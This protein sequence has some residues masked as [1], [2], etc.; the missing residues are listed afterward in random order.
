MACLGALLY[1]TWSHRNDPELITHSTSTPSESKS[2]AERYDW[3]GSAQDP[4]KLLIG[5]INVDVY[6]QRMGVDQNQEIAVPNNVFLAGWFVS[7]AQPGQKGLAII[8]GHVSGLENPGVF[9]HLD[10]MRVGDSFR[11]VR[12]DNTTLDYEVIST[13]TV[14]EQ[15]AADAIF[16]QDPST[17]SQVNLVTC[18]GRFDGKTN[19][20]DKRVIVAGKLIK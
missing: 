4:K 20:Y 15:E 14:K 10:N 5:S 7:S 16:S 8:A 1:S 12:G 17:S 9:K 18:G 6:I 3:R 11:I 2:D 19:R 13:V